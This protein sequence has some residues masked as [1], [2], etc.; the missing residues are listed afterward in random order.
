M[1]SDFMSSEGN[2]W[3]AESQ[4]C[5]R[6]SNSLDLK[7]EEVSV[8]EITIED[9][10]AAAHRLKDYTGNCEHL[11]GHNWKIQASYRSDELNATGIAFDFREARKLLRAVIIE[12]DH[13]YLNELAAFS[14][15][16]PSCENIARFIYDQLDAR[17]SGLEQPHKVRVSS[18]K[19]WES[20]HAWIE[21][22]REE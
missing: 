2:R 7:V 5:S 14:V 10:F 21:Y 17:L 1:R 9:E 13:R 18:V 11:H 4:T 22:R 20:A 12:L 8:Y 16:N 3:V 19:V 6:S 15:S